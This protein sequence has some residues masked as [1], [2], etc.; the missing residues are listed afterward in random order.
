MWS[1]EKF[2]NR[3]FLIEDIYENWTDGDHVELDQKVDPF[4]DPVEDVF[5]GRYA[6]V[7]TRDFTK[8]RVV[9]HC[10]GV[11]TAS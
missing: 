3:K 1:K 9:A 6:F 8:K 11:D 2:M 10:R 7:F 4:W 5:L